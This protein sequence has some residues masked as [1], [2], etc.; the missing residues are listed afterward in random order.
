MGDSSK[1][2]TDPALSKRFNEF[3]KT[4]EAQRSI[5]FE[6]NKE[7]IKDGIKR[8]LLTAM[9]GDSVSTAFMLKKDVQVKEALKYLSDIKLYNQAI[10]PPKAVKQKRTH[11][12]VK[13]KK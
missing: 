7:Y 1:T 11:K 13:D 12:K 6:Q 10:N 8:E 9:A 5:Q 3:K 4:L 2:I